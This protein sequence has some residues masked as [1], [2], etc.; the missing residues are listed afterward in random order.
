VVVLSASL[1]EPTPGASADADAL[2]NRGWFDVTFPLNGNDAIDV[3]SITDLDPEFT[4]VAPNGV[5]F[6]LDNSRAPV[7]IGGTGNTF[8]YWYTGNFTEGTLQL[9][10]IAGSFNYLDAA[11]EPTPNEAGAM[12][13]VTVTAAGNSTWIDI[14]F[15][16]AGGVAIDAATLAD[17]AREFTLSGA[18]LGGAS[19][20]KLR[21]DAPTLIASSTD[22][23]DNDGDG[24]VDE[25]DET[26]YRYYV[27]RG[28][29]LGSVTIA[30]TGANW[31]DKSGNPGQNSSQGFQVIETVKH[32]D[33]SQGGQA[34]GKVFFI[35]ISGGIK[36]QGLG[37][38]DEPII[39]IRGGVT[40]EIGQFVLP[41]GGTVARFTVDA[42]GTI[43]II[44]LGNIGSA[45]ARLV[46]QVGDTVSGDPEIW[47]VAKIQANFDFL[48]NYGIFAEGSALLQ[49]NTT[50]TP[51]TE[52]IVLEGIPGDVMKTCHQPF[53]SALVDR[54]AGRGGPAG[55]LGPRR[56]PVRGID[57]ASAHRRAAPRCR[58]SSDASSGRSSPRPPTA[59]SDLVFSSTTPPTASST[60]SPRADLRAAG[61][62]VLDRDRR[63]AEDQGRRL[64]GRERRGRGAPVRRLLPAHHAR[65]LRDLRPG[66]GADPGARPERQGGRPADHRRRLLQPGPARHRH[67]AEPRA[68]AGRLAR[69]RRR[70]RPGLG[71]DGIFE[72]RGWWWYV[73]RR[74]ASRYSRS[75]RV[76][77]CC[78]R[79]AHHGHGLRRG[80]RDR[81]LEARERGAGVLRLGHHPGQHHPVR[82]AHAVGLYL[83]HR[84]DRHRRQR[85]RAHRRRG[86]GEHRGPRR[87][88]G[89][90]RS[91]ALHQPRRRG[92]GIIGRVQLVAR[93]TG[94]SSES[95]ASTGSSCSK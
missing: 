16:T 37:F 69:R 4:V 18:G 90:P 15:T 61:A 91:A 44:K 63:L 73:N 51:K 77:T 33:V 1:A 62:V 14:G 76:S 38:T 45:A 93:P 13:P 57:H 74:C 35:E 30:F 12:T 29:V 82:H 48:K 80:A 40:L 88:L 78:R 79:R 23:I 70:Q 9:T 26:V 46:L 71:L 17:A 49:L 89:Q 81:R 68:D 28:F 21:D 55:G 84:R 32:D 59:S 94:C 75:R 41:S 7:R 52:K 65:A 95:S 19:G 11:N 85:L 8:R 20:A 39:D 92:S 42:H 67:D 64:V 87:V 54:R 72:L 53:T 56:Q 43:K 34:L 22:G 47:G 60:C 31:A 27:D 2:N 58:R 36:L 10:A 25:A 24:V 86:P 66:R 83:F 5:T 6:E 50:P 3:A